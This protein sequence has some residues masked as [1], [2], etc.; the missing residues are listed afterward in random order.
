MTLEEKAKQKAEEIEKEQTLGVYDNEEDL[1]R[2][3]AFNDGFVDGFEEGYLAGANEIKADCDFALE[4]KDLEIKELKEEI[5]DWKACHEHQLELMK[6]LNDRIADLEKML[7]EQY[8]DLKQSL[9]WANEREKELLEQIEK[10]KNCQNCK[11]QYCECSSAFIDKDTGKET[12]HCWNE[13]KEKYCDVGFEGKY[14][15]WE[16]KE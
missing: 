14:Q 15:C 8:P 11:W 3:S 4:G 16:L 1:V 6:G 13:E 5:E 9:D 10:M 7:S 2:D 12:K